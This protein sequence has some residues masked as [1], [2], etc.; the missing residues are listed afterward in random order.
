MQA[1][2]KTAAGRSRRARRPNSA[3]APARHANL[4]AEHGLCA[5]AR[6]QFCSVTGWLRIVRANFL[7]ATGLANRKPCT[8][9][10]PIS[11]TARKSARVSG[12]RAVALGEV[13]DLPADRA[14]QPVVGTALDE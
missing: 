11:R 12:T 7:A 1:A 13:E 5:A 8:R 9:S 6:Y 4:A 14:L 10:K 3:V 2:Q